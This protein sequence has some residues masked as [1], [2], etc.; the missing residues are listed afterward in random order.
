M[1]KGLTE[2][3]AVLCVPKT[4][5]RDLS[6]KLGVRYFDTGLGGDDAEDGCRKSKLKYDGSLGGE[7]SIANRRR[8]A[9]RR[10]TTEETLNSDGPLYEPAAGVVE[11]VVVGGERG[12]VEAVNAAF[13][14]PFCCDTVDIVLLIKYS[15]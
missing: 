9:I 5:K 12:G 3:A 15:S 4:S 14:F 10:K 8:R 11:L 13:F 7:G 2:T 6:G 1:I